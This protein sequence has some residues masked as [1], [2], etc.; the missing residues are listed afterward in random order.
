MKKFI[1]FLA[2]AISSISILQGCDDTRISEKRLPAQAQEFIS[3]Y[4]PGI[5]VTYAEKERDD[6][7]KEY[8]VKLADGTEIQFNEDGSW[9]SVDC[10][11]SILPEGIVPDSITDYV[12]AN[13]PESKIYKAEKEFGGYEIGL[14]GGVE[15][16]FNTAGEYV[17][18][19]R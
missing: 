4:F 3:Q 6:R 16:I 17:R 11:F 8:N 9:T 7:Q 5:S 18:V 1:V 10:E 15:L 2:A 13:Y 12:K 19:S 14:T